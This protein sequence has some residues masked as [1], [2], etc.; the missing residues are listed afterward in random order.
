MILPCSTSFPDKRI[1]KLYISS[2][3]YESH[4]PI[5]NIKEYLKYLFEVYELTVININDHPEEAEKEG[6]IATPT[7][8]EE[9]PPPQK[10]LV[11]D[12]SDRDMLFFAPG[13]YDI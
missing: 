11:G 10:R 1:L 5:K 12:F 6:I 13:I 8:I 4:R 9:Y 2:E 7:L 3:S